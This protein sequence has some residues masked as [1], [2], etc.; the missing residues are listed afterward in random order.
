MCGGCGVVVA[1]CDVTGGVRRKV[2]LGCVVVRCCALLCVVV[3]VVVAVSSPEVDA[4]CASAAAVH[5]LHPITVTVHLHP[6]ATYDVCGGSAQPADAHRCH[7]AVTLRERSRVRPACLLQRAC[8][9]AAAAAAPAGTTAS[10]SPIA[11]AALR[12]LSLRPTFQ[13]LRPILSARVASLLFLFLPSL[14]A[15]WRYSFPLLLL[16]LFLCCRVLASAAQQRAVGGS[17]PRASHCLRGA[18]A[19]EGAAQQPPGGGAVEGGRRAPLRGGHA[20]GRRGEG[21]GR[22]APPADHRHGSKHRAAA[23]QAGDAR[24]NPL[25]SPQPRLQPTSLLPPR[26]TCP[27]VRSCAAVV[28]QQIRKSLSKVQREQRR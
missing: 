9:A 16:L 10:A 17:V 11:V 6:S 7:V 4:L 26:L 1:A 21:H 15:A 18:R 12:P 3:V 25:S 24:R 5:H 14:S 28:E 13:L 2:V 20:E 8:H 19:S 23:R 27:S 22:H